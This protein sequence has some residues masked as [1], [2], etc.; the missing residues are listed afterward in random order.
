MTLSLL[1]LLGLNTSAQA[2]SNNSWQNL[3]DV[4][5]YLALGAA[6]VTPSV[7]KDWEGLGQ[8]A[9][10]IGVSSALTIALKNTVNRT[11]PDGS[12]RKSFPSGHAS[13][14]F[15]SATFLHRRYGWKAG[16]PAYAVA[17]FTGVARKLGQKH[18]WGDVA[19]GAAFGTIS[20]WIFTDPIND[21][22]QL[23]PWADHH[24]AGVIVAM[25]W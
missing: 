25:R 12:D 16:L 11:R 24:G 3:S 18:F 15:A 1:L 13:T 19:A 9:W 17:T 6:V 20:G 21:K 8:A 5:L 7:Q 2:I 22:V 14:T 10:S 4:G 23:I